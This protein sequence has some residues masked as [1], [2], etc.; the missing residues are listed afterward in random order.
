[1]SQYLRE[2]KEIA[3]LGTVRLS[4][5][6]VSGIVRHA[7]SNEMSI[8]FVFCECLQNMEKS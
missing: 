6:P 3:G 7:L 5:S 2:A 1:M 4:T 8:L